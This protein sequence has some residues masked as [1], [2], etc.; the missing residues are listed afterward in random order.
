M[1]DEHEN[2]ELRTLHLAF[3]SFWRYGDSVSCH[4]NCARGNLRIA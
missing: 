3:G 1:A 4:G 2:L